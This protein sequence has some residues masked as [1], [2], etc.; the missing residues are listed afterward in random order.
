[1]CQTDNDYMYFLGFIKTFEKLAG[2][3]NELYCLGFC[4]QV[5]C[6]IYSTSYFAVDCG[7]Q[8]ALWSLGMVIMLALL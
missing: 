1:M 2:I 8:Q 7:D 3:T 5:D 4:M 6:G